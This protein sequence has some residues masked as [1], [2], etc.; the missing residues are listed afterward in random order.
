MNAFLFL[1]ATPRLYI[2][3]RFKFIDVLWLTF[4]NSPSPFKPSA[5]VK[6]LNI[7][8]DPLQIYLLMILYFGAL[9]SYKSSKVF[10]LSKNL[11]LALVYTKIID[12]KLKNDLKS[13]KVE[14]VSNPTL[15]FFSSFLDL[16]PKYNR[17]WKKIPHLSHPI[18][19]SV[20]DYIPDGT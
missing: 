11:A 9:F 13:C 20:N 12:M 10:I 7:Y 4:Y 8:L 14:E 2:T 6:L 17:S 1:P 18:R 16:I 15:L 19:Y 3:N 5:W